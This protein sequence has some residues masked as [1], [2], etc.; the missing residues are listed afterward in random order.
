MYDGLFL[1]VVQ[2]AE[3]GLSQSS[4]DSPVLRVCFDIHVYQRYTRTKDYVVLR[5]G[6]RNSPYQSEEGTH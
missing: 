5:Q 6:E 3:I 1:A 4:G 2:N